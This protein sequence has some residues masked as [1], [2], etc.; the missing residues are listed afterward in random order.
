MAW[1]TATPIK[2]PRILIAVPQRN[3]FVYDEF[4]FRLHQMQRP[5]ETDVVFDSGRPLDITRNLFVSRC[6]AGGY[7]YL[8]FVDDDI[9]L[10]H[11]TLHKLVTA[12]VPVVS[13]VYFARSPPHYPLVIV[14]DQAIPKE[15]LGKDELLSVDGFGMG[16][17]LI[18]K[19][20]LTMMGKK[21]E[22]RCLTNHIKEVGKK[23]YSCDYETAKTDGFRCRH[24]NELM[25]ANYFD[26]TH[27]LRST[28]E[29][30]GED[31]Y[32]CDRV[33][34]LGQQVYVKADCF[35]GHAV[36]AIITNKG[37]YIK[38]REGNRT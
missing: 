33:K 19:S 26:H 7:D 31:Y 21:M 5:P 20:M 35:V 22:W 32:F 16:C 11:D 18:H 1:E 14:G 8:F 27:G 29:A 17:C 37:F 38:T 15:E 9:I 28:D 23:V 13:G 34:E 3:N 12:R 6:L 2:S 4:W 30:S 24:C 10:E 25:I 36:H